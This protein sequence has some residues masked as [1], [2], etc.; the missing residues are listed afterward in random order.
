[1]KYAIYRVYPRKAPEVVEVF[2]GKYDAAV[3]LDK[4]CS[5]LGDEYHMWIGVESWKV[6]KYFCIYKEDI[7]NTVYCVDTYPKRTRFRVR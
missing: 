4:L 3:A 5:S 7:T 2:N 1:M 6:N